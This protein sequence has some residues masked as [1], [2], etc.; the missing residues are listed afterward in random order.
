MYITLMML[1]FAICTS[2]HMKVKESMVVCV[3]RCAEALRQVMW[4]RL[5]SMQI[6]DFKI[7]AGCQKNLTV[8]DSKLQIKQE[9]NDD[10]SY[11]FQLLVLVIPFTIC[12][13][14][15]EKSVSRKHT[16][17]CNFFQCLNVNLYNDY[18]PFIHP[19][20]MLIFLA[21]LILFNLYRYLFKWTTSLSHRGEKQHT[22]TV[23]ND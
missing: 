5:C 17:R 10:L 6:C 3:K 8:S 11:L 15:R 13:L 2:F 16:F 19:A 7:P 23:Q 18:L 21:F 9:L 14:L 22:V 20:S 12:A 1:F 4:K